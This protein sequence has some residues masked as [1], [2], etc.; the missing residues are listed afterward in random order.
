MPADREDMVIKLVL[1]HEVSLDLAGLHVD[2]IKRSLD[3]FRWPSFR[4]RRRQRSGEFSINTEAALRVQI[5]NA[6]LTEHC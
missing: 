3:Y 4:R 6:L 1:R 2:E 5:R